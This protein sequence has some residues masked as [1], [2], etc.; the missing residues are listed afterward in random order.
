MELNYNKLDHIMDFSSKSGEVALFDKI[1]RTID[2]VAGEYT[3]DNVLESGK[4]IERAALYNSLIFISS[5]STKLFYFDVIFS[6][7]SVFFAGNQSALVRMRLSSMLRNKKQVDI[8]NEEKDKNSDDIENT[9]PPMDDEHII[10]DSKSLE[11]NS[12]IEDDI[13]INDMTD[14]NQEK[15]E[16]GD[17]DS[18]EIDYT[19]PVFKAISCVAFLRDKRSTLVSDGKVDGRLNSFFLEHQHVARMQRSNDT[20]GYLIVSTD[21]HF[22]DSK[23]KCVVISNEY[24]NCDAYEIYYDDNGW[25]YYMFNCDSNGR[26]GKR[27]DYHYSYLNGINSQDVY[28]CYNK[29]SS[30]YI[31]NIIHYG[32]PCKVV[33]RYDPQRTNTEKKITCTFLGDDMDI[34][35]RKIINL[36]TGKRI[37]IKSRVKYKHNEMWVVRGAVVIFD[38]KY[39][40]NALKDKTGR[41]VIV[42]EKSLRFEYAG[43]QDKQKCLLRVFD[44]KVITGRY[45]QAY[46][47]RDY[48]M[49]KKYEII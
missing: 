12:D 49:I 11:T 25:Y 27:V 38:K 2:W 20:G 30:D 6:N 3:V 18:E 21:C 22:L 15:F 26:L 41:R 48:S 39:N 23:Q 43:I 47:V 44:E 31:Q 45:M 8:D 28:D 42:A 32:I 24:Q 13:V 36:K 37:H 40:L 29:E 33:D 16:W 14:T 19:H 1:Y 34:G 7:F 46:K 9:S 35:A 5:G 10:D 17:D 4:I